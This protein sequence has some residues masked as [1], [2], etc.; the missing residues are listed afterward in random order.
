[1]EEV[2]KLAY[3]SAIAASFSVERALPQSEPKFYSPF[4]FQH[5][6]INVRMDL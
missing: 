2:Q 1:V 3:A 6:K 5:P 4:N